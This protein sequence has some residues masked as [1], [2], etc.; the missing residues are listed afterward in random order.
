LPEPAATLPP[1]ERGH[2]QWKALE[3]T[4]GEEPVLKTGAA[5]HYYAA[6]DT[7]ADGIRIGQQQEKFLFYRGVAN[8]AASLNARIT[9]ENK[10]ELRNTGD[11]A[12]PLAIL[13]ENRDGRIGYRVTRGLMGSTELDTPELTANL[14]RL[15]QNLTNA[16]VSAGLYRKEAAA[17]IETW[18]DSWFEE[19]MRVFY[20]APRRMVDRELPLA[21]EP[22]PAKTARVFV[23]R[24][25]LLAPFLRTRLVTAVETG[26]TKV[27]DQLGR[28]LSPFLQQVR[29]QTT[30]AVAQYLA[31]KSAAAQREFYQPS[32][33]R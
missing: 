30:P 4:P 17:M 8:F 14:D 23:G 5:S 16:L 26:D 7:D 2:I 28:F 21:I 1:V 10:V 27:L 24:V 11:D 12:M 9:R 15:K 18:R 22:A 31:A 32:C 6:R 25:E 33:V 19:G 13:F 29:G 20:L 3:I